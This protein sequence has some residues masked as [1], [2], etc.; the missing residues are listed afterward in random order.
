ALK[1]RMQTPSPTC[2][3]I[4]YQQCQR[5][6]NHRISDEIRR[7]TSAPIFDRGTECPS[8]LATDASEAVKNR[9]RRVGGVAYMEGVATGQRQFCNFVSSRA[10]TAGKWALTRHLYLSI[11]TD[12]QRHR[13]KT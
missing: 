10:G 3:F 4:Y 7:T 9:Q 13:A 1:P 12:L 11:R 2:P 6:P 5:T 8:K